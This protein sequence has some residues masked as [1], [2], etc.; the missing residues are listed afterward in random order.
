MFASFRILTWVTL[1]SC[2][3]FHA[4]VVSALEKVMHLKQAGMEP[5]IMHECEEKCLPWACWWPWRSSLQAV[6]G[7]CVTRGCDRVLGFPPGAAG[8]GQPPA[9]GEGAGPPAFPR[10][11]AQLSSAGHRFTPARTILWIRQ[12]IKPQFTRFVEVQFLILT[13]TIP[14]CAQE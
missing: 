10:G 13:P 11:S 1:G 8:R 7:V 5:C 4:Q 2:G 12:D 3:D 14:P 9:S 6:P